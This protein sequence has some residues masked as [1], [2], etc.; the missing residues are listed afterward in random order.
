MVHVQPLHV[1]NRGRILCAL[2]G[3]IKKKK[4]RKKREQLILS[5]CNGGSVFINAL[6]CGCIIQSL[7]LNQKAN[8][9]PHRICM[10]QKN[11]GTTHNNAGS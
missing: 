9:S 11:I 3:S 6:S 1:P 5:A 10:H 7:K 8:D 2:F 4:Q